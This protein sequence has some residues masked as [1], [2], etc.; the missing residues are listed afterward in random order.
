MADWCRQLAATKVLPLNGVITSPNWIIRMG[1]EAGSLILT[2]S[3]MP[4]FSVIW[5]L[6][7]LTRLTNGQ[8]ADTRRGSKR[9]LVSVRPL[10]P[11]LGEKKTNSSDFYYFLCDLFSDSCKCFQ[12]SKWH[13]LAGKKRLKAT[14]VRKVIWTQQELLILLIH[15]ET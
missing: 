3:A 10:Q 15:K 9:S 12:R 4:A 5:R 7:P 8:S 13:H 14:I 1:S 2:A 11:I 6:N